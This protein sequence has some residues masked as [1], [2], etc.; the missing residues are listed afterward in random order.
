MLQH[1]SQV[2]AVS[3]ASG[4]IGSALV[5]ALEQAGHAVLRLVRRPVEDSEREVYWNPATG[6]IDADTLEGVD[7]VIHLGG[8]NV[9]KQRWT[10]EYKDLLYKSRIDSTSLLARTL[11]SLQHRPRVFVV[12]SAVG[13]Y[14]V[15]G[16]ESLDEQSP[17]G[18]RFLSQ[19]CSDWEAASQPAEEAGVRCCQMRIGVVLS[20]EGGALKKML[21][22]F[23]QGLGGT[24]GTGRQ[25]VSW[26]SL[27]DALAILQLAIDDDS[28]EGPVNA[29]APNPVTN[30]EMAQAL[31]Q[32]LGR[33]AR[34]PT[35]AFALRMM[36]GREMAEELLLG[37]A[38]IYPRKLEAAG[39]SFAH[40]TISE[41]ISAVLG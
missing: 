12:A 18:S 10:K 7:G 37:G 9:A 34:L 32:H 21:P 13:Y 29:T 39:F 4:L 14:G 36:V 33:S 22:L 25:Y 24:M 5:P 38:K 40:S 16:D 26:I 11:A 3:G 35:P 28:L 31:A 15:R 30:H 41:A 8:A 23:R 6:E 1:P 2:L 27:P 17:A 19:L 20:P